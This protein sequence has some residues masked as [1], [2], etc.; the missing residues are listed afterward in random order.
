MD[1]LFIQFLFLKIRLIFINRIYYHIF[2][3]I[4]YLRVVYIDKTTTLNE[5]IVRSF[6]AIYCISR[7][8]VAKKTGLSSFKL[9]Q[10]VLLK[11]KA[12]RK[13]QDSFKS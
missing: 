10:V 6:A 5:I 9:H 11:S 12:S 3:I 4:D 8:K 7:T 13:I 2:I 1:Q